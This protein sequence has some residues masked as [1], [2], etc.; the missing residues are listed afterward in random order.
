LPALFRG[1][2]E[3]E[4]FGAKAKFEAAEQQQ[5]A[6]IENPATQELPKTA[7][8]DPSQRPADNILETHLRSE[9][10]HIEEGKRQPILIR[11]LAMS[12]LKAGHNYAY[13][14]IFGS[15]ITFL[16]IFYR[17]VGVYE[18][19]KT[20]NAYER[21]GEMLTKARRA[22][23]ISMD[24][25]RD[26]GGATQE[27]WAH[28]SPQDF[29]AS[30]RVLAEG[31]RR[32]R[33]EGQ[34][35]KLMLFCEAAGMVP[36]LAALAN[37]YGLPVTSSGGFDSLTDKHGLAKKIVES[38]VLWKCCISATV[39]KAASIPRSTSPRMSAPFSTSS[40]A[41]PNLSGLP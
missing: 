40:A 31:Y 4:A 12:Q 27:P 13:I 5:Q 6:V 3:L 8:L 7:A 32:D 35:R 18:Y 16:K 23:M 33:T 37:P 11:T 15:Q 39:T 17:L 41:R 2:V 21:L 19:E 22:R 28:D 25:I 24:S 36:Q 1:K 9:I 34:T 10:E 14:Q 38:G 26:D 30:V 20:E 29:L